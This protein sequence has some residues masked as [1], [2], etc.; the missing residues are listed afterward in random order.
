MGAEI[1][2]N[3]GSV[4]LYAKLFC[5]MEKLLRHIYIILNWCDF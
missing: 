1:F 2:K 3:I 5:N 4:L